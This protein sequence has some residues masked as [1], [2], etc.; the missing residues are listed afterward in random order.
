MPHLRVFLS[1]G[2]IVVC[3]FVADLRILLCVSVFVCHVIVVM[4]PQ[5]WISRDNV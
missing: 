1:N 5:V 4:Y 3:E 2:T